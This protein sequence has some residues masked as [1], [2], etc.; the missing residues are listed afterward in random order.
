MLPR[1][2]SGLVA[3]LLAGASAT[4]CSGQPAPDPS[5]PSAPAFASDEE[6]F[7]A[8]EET[9]RA[10]V[11]ALNEVDLSDPATFEPVFA[12][13]TGEANSGARREFSEMHAN[14]WTVTGETRVALVAPHETSESGTSLDVCLDVSDVAVV[15]ANG[16]SV[17]SPDRRNIQSMRVVLTAGSASPTGLLIADIDGREG[18]PQCNG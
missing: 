17:V 11:D 9:Y 8:A 1:I 13:T 5:T 6:A 10:Y 12:W 7:A 18:Q 15:D 16:Q 3:L 14:V 4:G 2:V